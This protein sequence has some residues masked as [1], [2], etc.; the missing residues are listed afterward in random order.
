MH[1][2]LDQ[3]PQN[4]S[5][6]DSDAMAL[7][8]QL[9]RHGLYTTSPNPRV[10][11]VL[12]KHEHIIASG[13]HQQAGGK[14]AEIEALKQAGDQAK[15]ATAYVTLEPCSHHGKTPPCADALIKAGVKRVIAAMVDPN[16]QVA[17]RGLKKLHDAGIHV[18]WG[19]MEEESKNLN[20]GFIKRMLHQQPFVRVKM[21]TSLDGRTA[22]ASGESKWIT[23]PAA[24]A[25]VQRWRA[26]SCAIVMGVDSVLSDNPSM[27]VRKSDWLGDTPALWETQEIRQ[28]LRIV[29]DSQ[30]RIPLTAKLL[31]QAG[32]TWVVT[33]ENS[34]Q[35]KQNKIKELP[36]LGTEVI[37]IQSND[38]IDLPSLLKKLAEREVNE[39]LVE[40]GP[41]L[42]GAFLQ[43]EL[44]DELIFY[45][46]PKLM[47]HAAKPS[48]NLPGL[49]KMSDCLQ[50]NFKDIRQVGEDLR[51]IANPL[52]AA[53]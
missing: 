7:A 51:I 52:R 23:G 38:Q 1:T 49:E 19:L 42:A 47:G 11:C 21:A 31:Q 5:R 24:R 2:F 40:T 10:G 50:L 36:N 35:S 20:P 45:M 12:S 30:L 44:V 46:A 15:G 34:A 3:L 16:P 18:S 17:G 32:E 26:Q 43:A 29:L 39:V 27:T 48:L 37:T 14:H 22:M 28:P 33:T 4:F 9:A 6:H 25:D 41:T 13:W 53:Q 8:I